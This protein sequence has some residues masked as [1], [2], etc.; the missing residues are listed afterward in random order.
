MI[1]MEECTIKLSPG[2]ERWLLIDAEGDTRMTL[3]A[4]IAHTAE[5]ADEYMRVAVYAYNEGFTAGET[6]GRYDIK[7]ELRTLLGAATA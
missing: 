2:I 6:S 4:T 1:H 5:E 3:P 7:C